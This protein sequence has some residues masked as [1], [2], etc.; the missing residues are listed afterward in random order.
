[1]MAVTTITVPRPL[2]VPPKRMISKPITEMMAVMRMI[3]LKG[4]SLSSVVIYLETRTELKNMATKSEEPKTT[5]SVIGKNFMNSPII[6][7]H[8]ANG[9][10]AFE[11]L[12]HN[13]TP[14]SEFILNISCEGENQSLA[15]GRTRIIKNL[16]D[17]FSQLAERLIR[18]GSDQLFCQNVH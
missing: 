11:N 1:M 2:Y 12:I 14:L 16:L 5:D 7:G 4:I 10:K 15:E 3:C 13:A 18:A 6:P 17:F 9:T 8:R